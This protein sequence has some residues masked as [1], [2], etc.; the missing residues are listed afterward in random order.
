MYRA[1][2]RVGVFFSTGADTRL[3]FSAG[4]SPRLGSRWL[5]PGFPGRPQPVG[6]ED[7]TARQCVDLTPAWIM[8]VR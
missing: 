1:V 5:G 6:R 4:G 7:G 2:F 3:R 8:L